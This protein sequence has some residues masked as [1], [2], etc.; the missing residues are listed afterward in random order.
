MSKSRAKSSIL[1]TDVPNAMTLRIREEDESA[2]FVHYLSFRA[3]FEGSSQH[4]EQFLRGLISSL[5]Q[6]AL[7]AM[8]MLMSLAT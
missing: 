6:K 4:S 2:F 7:H 8:A 5:Y 1:G 3:T